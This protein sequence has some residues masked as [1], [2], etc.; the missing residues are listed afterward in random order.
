[1]EYYAVI[2]NYIDL[3]LLIWGN[4]QGILFGESGWVIKIACVYEFLGIKKE[5]SEYMCMEKTQQE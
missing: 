4:A 5:A 1:M 2:K 3:Y